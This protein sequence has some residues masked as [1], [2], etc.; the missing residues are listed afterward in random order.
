M[1]AKLG[2]L[3]KTRYFSLVALL[4]AVILFFQIT[5]SGGAY[6]SVINIRSILNA[7]AIVALLAIGAAYVIIS[8]YVDLSA[9]F[10]GTFSGMLVAYFIE[11]ARWPWPLAFLAT[12]VIAMAVGFINATLIHKLGFQAF[13]ATIAMGSICEGLSFLLTGGRTITIRNAA[14][15][16]IGT[17]RF[18]NVIPSSVL[19]AAVA[20]IIYGIILSRT[21]FGRK[22]YLVG[23]N[24]NAAQ[25]TGL[26][27]VKVSYIV[28]VNSAAMSALAGCLV[29]SRVMAGTMGGII[30]Q[31]F[32]GITAA[33]LG[34]ISFG[35]GTGSVSGIIIGL[36]IISC[37][38]NGLTVLRIE[39]Y[40]AQVASGLLLVLAIAL[41][42]LLSRQTS[43]AGKKPR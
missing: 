37:F 32:A 14:F 27:P 8:G 35:G 30:T 28:F 13:I 39:T 40:W 4:V 2:V 20:L 6:L 11:F 16:S 9:G 1:K 10:V 5:S 26:K 21:R 3:F 42:N 31:N 36:L 41:D 23:G 7:T 17:S 15:N 12:M 34:G 19:I 33:I 29:A 18:F 43:G 22:V 24:Q 25:L 38:S